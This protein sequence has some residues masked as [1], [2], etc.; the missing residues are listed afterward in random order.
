MPNCFSLTRKSD[1][2]SGPVPFN[3]IDEEMCA[4]FGVPCHPTAW[5]CYWYDTIGFALAMG[6]SFEWMRDKIKEGV[7]SEKDKA[8]SLKIIDWLDENF[9][10][11]AWAVVGRR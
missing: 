10:P 3:V 5:Y 6:K 8:H 9:T 7:E 4:Y 1:P 11:D 2:A